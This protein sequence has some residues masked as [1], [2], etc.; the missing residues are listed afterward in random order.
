MRQVA[1][2]G[3]GKF[4]TAV[5][6]ELIVQGAEVIAIDRRKE[7]VEALKDTVTYAATLNATDENALRGVGVQNVDVAVGCIGDDVEANLL[8]TLLLK[9][10]GV[11][12]VWS[13]AISPLQKEI[14]RRLEVDS[15]M[16]LEED[17]G[18]TV[19]RSLV[20]SSVAKHI[21][22]G[23]GY[24]IAE[25]PVPTPFIG[26]TI[27]A[28]MARNTHNVNL[29]AIKKP[30]PEITDAGE[31]TFGEA[32]ENIPGPDATFEEGDILVVVGR[33]SDIAKIAKV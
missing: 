30:V 25:L 8:T 28:V 7:P 17:M 31:R 14:L 32:V 24:G 1:V 3:L 22:L 21:P 13:R 20:S 11:K 23:K 27:H 12:T 18:H 10:L 4:G 16:N 19:A 5:A 26:Q 6:R 9:K 2:I 15:I 29:V 33:D